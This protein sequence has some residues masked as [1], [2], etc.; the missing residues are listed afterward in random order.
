MSK[1]DISNMATK[2]LKPAAF[3][4]LLA[5]ADQ[6]CHG[7]GVMQAVREQ[8]GGRVPFQTGSF[9]RHLGGLIAD[10]LVAESPG[11]REA[12]DPRRGTFY[13]LTTRGRQALERERQYLG[14]VV[15]A[16]DRVRPRRATS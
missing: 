12:E 3:H 14:D 1:M 10:G 5:L 16:L 2:P 9:Y 6:D 11:P 13:Q 8:S 15:A 4:I 7:Y